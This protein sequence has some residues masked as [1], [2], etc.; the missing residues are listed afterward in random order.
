MSAM[1]GFGYW[2]PADENQDD[3]VNIILMLT[4]LALVIVGVPMILLG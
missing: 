2:S 4:V 3:V 1:N